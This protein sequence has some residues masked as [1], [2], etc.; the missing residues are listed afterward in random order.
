MKCRAT[1]LLLA[2]FVAGLG[3]ACAG[4]PAPLTADQIPAAFIELVGA[5]NRTM[6][7][8]WTGTA[9]MAGR[10]AATTPFNGSF[11]FAGEDFAGSITTQMSGEVNEQ[12][13]TETN[14][15]ELAFVGGQAF[16]RTPYSGGWQQSEAGGLPMGL[17]PLRNLELDDIEYV[18][19]ETRDEIDVHHLRVTDIESVASG[20]F[21]GLFAVQGGAAAFDASAS[22]FDVYVD[23]TAKPVSAS[24]QLT[25]DADTDEFGTINL[26]S[27]YTFSNWGVEIYIVAPVVAP[28]A[29][30]DDVGVPQPMP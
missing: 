20:L 14:S 24:L 29:G 4:S 5:P 13:G 28:N 18:G 8:E 1:V 27:S 3:G 19:T 16:T 30:G 17:D 12:P 22:S 15:T 25:T 21:S 11:D 2:V 6:H 9:A 7:M 23:A 26:T 10:G